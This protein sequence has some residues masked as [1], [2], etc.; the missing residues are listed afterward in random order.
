MFSRFRDIF[1]IP[2]LRNRILFTLALLAV[3]RLGG[4][5]PLP[6]VDTKALLSFFAGARGTIL[7][8]YDIFVGGNLANGTIFG[9]GIMPY[10]SASIILQLLGAA[11][12]YFQKLMR[13]GEEGRR[14]ITQY[15]RYLTVAIS[16]LQGFGIAVMLENLRTPGGVVVVNPGLRFKFLTVLTLVA[17]TIF[18]MWLGE[19]I[20]E[21]GIGNGISLIIMVGIIA[22][23]PNYFIRMLQIPATM[24][25]FFSA[26]PIAQEVVNIFNPQSWIYNLFYTGLIVFFAYF[27]TAIVINPQDLA[28]N[29]KRYG[30]F[31]P[32]VRPG[33]KTAQYIDHILTRITLPG[34]LFF[35][36]AAIVPT[37]ITTKLNVPFYFGGT[38]LIIVVGV[39]LDTLRQ[40]EAHLVMRH[41]EGFLHR[42]RIRGRRG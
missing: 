4:H 6:G 23:F 22:R 33:E 11:V 9:L 39:A 42:G 12:P 35:A 32:G 10:I 38:S 27:Y 1:K 30:G 18:I 15:T 29:L 28:D 2:D 7:G 13:E 40:V 20:T 34:A 37:Y 24:A 21:R 36:F 17:G 19:L 26:N 41:Y 25:R 31:I 3:Y 16:T 8:L 14:K 5:I